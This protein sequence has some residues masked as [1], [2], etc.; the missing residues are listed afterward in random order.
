MAPAPDSGTSLRKGTLSDQAP[1]TADVTPLSVAVAADE[2]ANSGGIAGGT[3]TPLSLV[4]HSGK[5]ADSAVTA[6]VAAANEAPPFDNAQVE[7]AKRGDPSSWEAAYLAYGKPLMGYLMV[8]LENRDDAAEALSETFLRAIDKASNFRGDAYAFRAWL[9]T[10]ARHVST[11]QYRRRARLVVLPE[12]PD[13]EDRSQPSG[14]DLTILRED[15][16]ELRSG[17]AR[18]SKADQEI[19][20]LRVCSGLSAADVGA[21]VGKKAG[22]VRM[23]QMRA[24]ESLRGQVNL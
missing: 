6:T 20:W 9:F 21:V 2:V 12:H 3:V 24:L 19:L 4:R 15:V 16:A 23:Q 17:F 13:R 22:A 10:I 18:L 8:R 14:E 1:L 11:D 7:A 5:A